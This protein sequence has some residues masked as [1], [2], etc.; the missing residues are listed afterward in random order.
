MATT[1]TPV[2]VAPA[3]RGLSRAGLALLLAILSIPGV[4]IAWDLPAGGF[5]TGVP[6]AIA[7]VVLGVRARRGGEPGRGKALAAIVVASLALL[8]VVLFI[9]GDALG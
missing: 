8:S 2:N 7:A 1:R 9:L 3:R 4:T 6:M 5:W